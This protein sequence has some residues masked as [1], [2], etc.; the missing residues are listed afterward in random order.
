MAFGDNSVGG[1]VIQEGIMPVKLLLAAD[2]KVGDLLGYSAGWK[3]ADGN[4]GIYAEF[5]AGETQPSGKIITAY[6]QG[7]ISG[8]TTGTA[9]NILYLSDNAGAYAAS[10]GTVSQRV[11]IE[12]GDGEIMVQPQETVLVR[13]GAAK[14]QSIVCLV[15]N[16]LMSTIA[17]GDLVTN[18]TPGFAGRIKKVYW[19]QDVPVTTAAKLSTLNLEIGAV[20]VTGGE[21]ALTSA[22]CTPKGK[23]IAGAAVTAL[24]IF[25]A[26]DTISVEAAS[27]TSFVEGSGSLYVVLEA[28]L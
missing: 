2:V 15:P 20:N 19:V 10:A 26:T 12:L 5:F 18:I 27:T 6:R 28:D 21:V 1:R 22:A 11:G 9:G 25:S 14:A 8:I 23:V 16:I 7:R 3:Q 17:D 13:A 24:N 4:A